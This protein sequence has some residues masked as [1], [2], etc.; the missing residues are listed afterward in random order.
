MKHQRFGRLICIALLSVL[1]VANLYAQNSFIYINN[2]A[3]VS[4]FS[5]GAG[6]SLSGIPGS[7]FKT[8]GIPGSSGPGIVISPVR[9]FLYVNNDNGAKINAFAI[10]PNTGVLTPVPASPFDTATAPVGGLLL[11]ITPNGQFLYAVNDSSGTIAAFSIAADGGLVPLYSLP[12]ATQFIAGIKVSPNGNFLFLSLNFGTRVAVYSIASNGALTPVSGSPFRLAAEC[13]NASLDINCAGSLLFAA[14]NCGELF[15]FNIA[16]DGVLTAVSGSPFNSGHFSLN[17]ILLNFSGNLLFVTDIRFARIS[18]LGIS[19]SG[20][21]SPVPISSVN[22]TNPNDE[23]SRPV[24]LALNREETLLYVNS[25]NSTIF[26]FS[27]S[28]AGLLTPVPGS[29]FPGGSGYGASITAYP[30]KNCGPIFD[31]CIQDDSNGSILRINSTTG[32][33]LF[34]NCSGFTLS[35]TASLIK[36]GSLI[37]LQQFGV[38]RRALATIDRSVNKGTASIQTQGRTFT[39]TDRNTANDTCACTPP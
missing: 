5:V 28:S 29:P 27:V 25:A 24:D 19:P 30:G 14:T 18:V 26:V 33:Y 31:I 3:S 23:D 37:S 38:D 13:D 21:V 22:I 10:D 34:T 4:G 35:G 15:V 39:I 36:R 2:G 20:T 7:P 17:H 16:S 9:N 1:P 11:A 8:G 32:D 12:F 6:S